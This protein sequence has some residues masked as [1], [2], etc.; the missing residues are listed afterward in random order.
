MSMPQIGFRRGALRYGV[1]PDLL[2]RTPVTGSIP[3][4]DEEA[5]KAMG[6]PAIPGVPPIVIIAPPERDKPFGDRSPAD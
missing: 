5:L 4:E 1:D 2:L 3:A 6:I